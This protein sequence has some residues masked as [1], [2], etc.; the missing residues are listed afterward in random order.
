MQ[1]DVALVLVANPQRVELVALQAGE[2]HA[3][4]VLDH[5]ALLLRRWGVGALEGDNAA[6]VLPFAVDAVDQHLGA[7]GI[8]AEHD[9]G[10]VAGDELAPDAAAG[11]RVEGRHDGIAAILHRATALA[12]ASG[13]QLNQHRAPPLRHA[14]RAWGG[15]K[16]GFS[17]C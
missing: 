13:E 6:G 8:A 17:R 9:R 14:L 1:L 15:R 2:G 11:F 5:L 16:E 10:R 12:G 3:L 7:G 4:E